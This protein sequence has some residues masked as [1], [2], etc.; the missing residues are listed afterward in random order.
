MTVLLVAKML[1]TAFKYFIW[2]SE[3]NKLCLKNSV[4]SSKPQ[5]KSYSRLF[6]KSKANFKAC[7]GC[8]LS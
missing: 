1:K 8:D 5:I 7:K 6:V 2:G 4:F 3:K